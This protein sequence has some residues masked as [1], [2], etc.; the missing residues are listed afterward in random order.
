M[1]LFSSKKAVISDNFSTIYKTS[2]FS[3]NN[4][5]TE[6]RKFDPDSLTGNQ[7][8]STSYMEQFNK[9]KEML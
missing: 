5:K 3:E 9:K 7:R 8:R 1:I 2:E 6:L 4:Y